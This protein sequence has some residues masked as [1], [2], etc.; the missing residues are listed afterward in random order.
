[1][2]Q[3]RGPSRAMPATPRKANRGLVVALVLGTTL[4][5][6]IFTGFYLFFL[7][8]PGFLRPNQEIIQHPW[9]RVPMTEENVTRML[10]AI[11]GSGGEQ[12]PHTFAISSHG[13]L[14]D[15][16][17]FPRQREEVLG[18]LIGSEDRVAIYIEPGWQVP[19][20]ETSRKLLLRM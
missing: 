5:I 14:Q 11:Q 2:Q 13:T 7:S 6:C 1:S 12:H 17:E 10:L 20:W 4:P 16:G 15:L 3:S 18:C 8:S 9:W 19:S